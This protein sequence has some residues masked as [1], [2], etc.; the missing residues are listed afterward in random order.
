MHKIPL[1]KFPKNK[2]P[3]RIKIVFL[4]L[5]SASVFIGNLR[6]LSKAITAAL[7]GLLAAHCYIAF[8]HQ[9]PF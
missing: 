1:K 4:V 8:T 6:W 3:H 9:R 2:P 5:S 7:S